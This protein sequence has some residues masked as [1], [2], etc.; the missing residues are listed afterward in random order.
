MRTTLALKDALIRGNIVLYHVLNF[1]G[2]IY[3]FVIIHLSITLNFI[4]KLCVR[5]LSCRLLLYIV[6]ETTL[7]VWVQSKSRERGF[8]Y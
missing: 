7:V 4:L 3:S 2:F 5:F 1:A 8:G 6:N